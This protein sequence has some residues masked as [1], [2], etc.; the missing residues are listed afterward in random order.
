M[1]ETQLWKVQDVAKFLG[2]S[3]AAI[4]RWM[5]TDSLPHV[6]MVRTLRFRPSSIQEWVE[7]KERNKDEQ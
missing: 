6:K 5:K 1:N 4:K 7:S 3:N 2:C